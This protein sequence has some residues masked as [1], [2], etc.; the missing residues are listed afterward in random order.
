M[1][2]KLPWVESIIGEDGGIQSAHSLICTK[3][4]DRDNLLVPQLDSLM[5]HVGCRKAKFIIV[6]VHCVVGQFYISKDYIHVKIKLHFLL[7]SVMV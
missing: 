5:K 4:E 7:P 3:I 2:T 1:W 6:G